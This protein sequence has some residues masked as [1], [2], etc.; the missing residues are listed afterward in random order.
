MNSRRTRYVPLTMGEVSTI[1]LDIAR[2][3]AARRRR[4]AAQLVCRPA[5]MS[6]S[7]T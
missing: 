3:S 6:G 7:A 2:C 4:G 1:G 5:S